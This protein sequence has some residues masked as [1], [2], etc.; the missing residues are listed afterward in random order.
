[1]GCPLAPVL[2]NIFMGF[3]ESKRFNEYKPKFCLRYV[4]DI[5]D[6]F[7]NQQDSLNVLNF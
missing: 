4:D 1:M 2:D 5:L 3:Y 6:A 7:D